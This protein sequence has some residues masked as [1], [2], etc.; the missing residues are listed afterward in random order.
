MDEEEIARQRKA[1]VQ[2]LC[3]TFT[4]ALEANPDLRANGPIGTGFGEI[5]L[6]YFVCE[7]KDNPFVNV[8]DI[9][10]GRQRARAN[11]PGEMQLEADAGGNQWVVHHSAD[12]KYS[13]QQLVDHCVARLRQV[14]N[15]EQGP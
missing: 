15:S 7:Y 9:W 2:S 8:L 10:F 12:Q 5:Q 3:D 6:G 1:L 14:A 4:V 11:H 13:N